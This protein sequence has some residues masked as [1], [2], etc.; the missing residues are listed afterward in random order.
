[1][2]TSAFNI[3]PP[4]G[5][6]INIRVEPAAANLGIISDANLQIGAIVWTMVN[7]VLAL[8]MVARIIY[9]SVNSHNLSHPQ[10][11]NTSQCGNLLAKIFKKK[12]GNVPLWMGFKI[13]TE[14]VFPFLLATVIAIQGNMFLYAETRGIDGRME[15]MPEC[16]KV[17]KVV[18]AGAFLFLP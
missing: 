14:D 11:G 13:T 15:M 16:K 1:M 12:Q 18:W 17:T 7:V 8:L 4:P 5:P 10:G 6:R 3:V 2:D 9:V